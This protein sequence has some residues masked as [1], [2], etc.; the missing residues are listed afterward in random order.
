MSQQ[1]EIPKILAEAMASE[2]TSYKSTKKFLSQLYTSGKYVMQGPGE[3]AGIVDLGKGWALAMRIESHNHPSFIKPYHG[4]ATGV[5]GILR[6]IFTMGARPIALLDILRF[7]SDK[8]ARHILGEAVHGIADYGNCVG[9]PIVGGDLYFDSTYNQNCLVN[10]AA[11][12]LVRK[13]KIIY[14]NA[15]TLGNDLIYAGARTGR[16][17]VGGAQMAS[18]NLDVLN[19][20][21]VQEADAFLEKLLLEACCELADTKWIEGM[22]DMGAAGLLCSTSEV[23]LRGRKKTKNN[24]GARV[25]LNRVP[26]KAPNISPVEMLLSESQERMLIVGHRKHRAKILNVFKKWDLEAHVIGTV[27]SDGKYTIVYDT[28]LKKNVVLP[29]EFSEIFPDVRED[30]DLTHWKAQRTKHEKAARRVTQEIWRQYDWM[31]GVRTLKGPN[32][33]GRYAVLDAPEIGKQIIIAWS[34]DEGL[35]DRSPTRGIEHAFDTCLNRLCSL[36][37]TPLGITNCLNFGHPKDS[38]GAF[39]ETVD[40][41][42]KRCKNRKIPV[43][44]GNV[45]L[46]NAYKTHSIKPT[47]VLVMAGVKQL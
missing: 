5:G 32:K 26:T 44:S 38:M 16:D 11:F 45:S 3:N 24:L 47:P 35:S 43:V 36:G 33:P 25:Y 46:Y 17:G 41:L 19:E 20:S 22:Q 31:V 14:G 1:S 40:A 9:V 18:A 37:A 13:D 23:I 2:H 7:G 12:G 29:M 6:D 4:A 39:S 28:P 27:T 15:L 34:S 21:A 30:W 42:T 10:V 8:N